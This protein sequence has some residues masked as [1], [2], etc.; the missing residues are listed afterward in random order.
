VEVRREKLNCLEE[1]RGQKNMFKEDDDKVVPEEDGVPAW[2]HTTNQWVLC[3]ELKKAKC[4]TKY[5]FLRLCKL[6]N[7]KERQLNLKNRKK[8][9]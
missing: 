6:T 7:T 1:E 3:M 9:N 2:D 5:L 4:D 8:N